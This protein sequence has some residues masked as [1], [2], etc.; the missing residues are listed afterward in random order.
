M[1]TNVQSQCAQVLFQK[2]QITRHQRGQETEAR[3]KGVWAHR[4]EA[5]ARKEESHT[6][7]QEEGAY[8]LS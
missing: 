6:P 5:T 2:N 8:I 7:R 1:T 4:Q 3:Q